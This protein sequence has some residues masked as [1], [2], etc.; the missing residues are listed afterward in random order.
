MHYRSSLHNRLETARHLLKFHLFYSCLC[1]IRRC[2]RRKRISRRISWFDVHE[3]IKY[4]DYGTWWLH[5][6]NS[7]SLSEL[8]WPNVM[9]RLRYCGR[10]G[11]KVTVP[12][13]W[14]SLTASLSCEHWNTELI[15]C[16]Y[17]V[18]R[19]FKLGPSPAWVKETCISLY[20]FLLS[21]PLR[22][23]GRSPETPCQRLVILRCFLVVPLLFVH[24]FHSLILRHCQTSTIFGSP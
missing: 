12:L 23:A 14:S 22:E 16:L 7:P 17:S 19:S 6:A 15:L 8:A 13:I 24:I 5:T 2:W 4:R 1:T 18:N 20:I 11:V 10:R 3:R 21:G 9:R